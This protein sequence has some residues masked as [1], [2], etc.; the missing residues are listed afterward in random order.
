MYSIIF[1]YL[2]NYSLINNKHL[3]Y[4]IFDLNRTWDSISVTVVDIHVFS[5]LKVDAT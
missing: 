1:I 5:L 2:E 3:V 4:E